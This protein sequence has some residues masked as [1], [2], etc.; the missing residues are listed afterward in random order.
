MITAT[1]TGIKS[2]RYDNERNCKR[3]FYVHGLEHDIKLV[4]PPEFDLVLLKSSVVHLNVLI[5]CA[6]G[7]LE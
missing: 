6:A 1:R 2:K 7:N 4:V 3:M 5:L